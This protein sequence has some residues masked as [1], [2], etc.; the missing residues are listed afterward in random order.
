MVRI[1]C[2]ILSTVVGSVS[3]S[4]DWTDDYGEAL[5]NARCARRPMVVV[6]ENPE[7][8]KQRAGSIFHVE[9]E[10]LTRFEIC[11][12]DVGSEYGKEVAKLYSPSELPYTVITDSECD[13]IVFRGVGERSVG[14]WR[15]TLEDHAEE[16][17]AQA[18][19]ASPKKAAKAQLASARAIKTSPQADSAD[20]ANN[21]GALFGHSNLADAQNAA[22]NLLVYVSMDD[23]KYCDKMQLET[24]NDPEVISL[25]QNKFESVMVRRE[26][27]SAFVAEHNISIFPATLILSPNGT[28]L[29]KIEGYVPADVFQSRVNVTR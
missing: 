29:T 22:R 20:I 2:L 15:E 21:P 25:L 16:A 1:A 14:E 10:L 23:C 3:L 5:E 8:V 18:K 17:G 28:L 13:R 19:P 27:Q 26:E 11:R 9:R 7:K 12:V 24:F 4:P 6:L